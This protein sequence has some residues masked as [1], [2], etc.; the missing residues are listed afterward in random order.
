MAVW[1]RRR[2]D[3]AIWR[4]VDEQRGDQRFFWVKGQIAGSIVR[5]EI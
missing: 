3:N 5:R 4:E 1:K 2:E